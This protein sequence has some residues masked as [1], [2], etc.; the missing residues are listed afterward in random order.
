MIR[1]LIGSSNVYRH[2]NHNDF[3]EYPKFKMVNCTSSEVFAAALDGIGEGKGQVIISVIE[4]LLCDAV[5]DITDPEKLNNSLE[6]A[7][8]SYLNVVKEVAIKRPEIKFALAQ[9]TLRPF[10]HWFTEGHNAFC[11]KIGEGIRIMDCRN[12]SKIEAPIK[13]SQ[14]FETDGVHLTPSSGKVFVNALLYNADALFNAEVIDL[15]QQES[16]SEEETD[17]NPGK[18]MAKHISLVKLEIANLK[19]DIDR[20]RVDDCMVTAPI[21]EELD[22]LSNVKK[23]DRIIL[24]GLTSKVPMPEGFEEKKKW[25]KELVGGVL[26]QIEAGSSSHVLNVMQGWKGSSNFIPLAEVRMDNAELAGRLK[27]TFATKK[28]AGIDFGRTYIAK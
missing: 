20:R 5:K 23:E 28:K 6:S 14:V 21:R 18:K 11:T 4:N 24:T 22:F 9:P 3:S 12:V 25:L 19:D 27:K 17:T 1:L 16:E 10:H 26:D 2:Y 15:D 8:K 13:M 7:I